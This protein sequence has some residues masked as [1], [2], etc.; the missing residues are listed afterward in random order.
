MTEGNFVD[1]VKIFCR[2]GKGGKGSA[3]FTCPLERAGK[4]VDTLEGKNTSLKGGPMVVMEVVEV[5]LL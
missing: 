3:H 2:S 1:Y 4:G 5:I